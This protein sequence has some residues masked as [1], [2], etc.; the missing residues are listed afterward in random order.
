MSTVLPRRR[1]PGRV[2][3]RSATGRTLSYAVMALM[4][5]YYL[6]PIW[7]LV[8]NS[9]K[10][11]LD[12][13]DSPA[14]WFGGENAF[15][16][17]IA[18]VFTED[19]GAFGFW[20]LNTVFYTV[21]SGFGSLIVSTV[22][23]Y[24]FAKYDFPGKRLAFAALLGVLMVPATALVIPQFLVMTELHLINTPWAV[25]IPGLLNPFGVYLIRIYA[26]D[27]VSDELLEASR[28]DG[29]GEIRAFR[30]VV[31]PLLRPAMATVLI[32]SL[33]G[34]WN[35]YFLPLLMLSDS[36]LFPI[37]VGLGDWYARAEAT[38]GASTPLYNLVITGSLIAIVPLVVSFVVLQRHWTSGLAMGSLK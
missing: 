21:A 32:F 26:Q 5:A 12:L 31:L 20:L 33:V 35:N 17:N 34:A 19:D 8:A 9:T 15:F 3:A 24:A 27:A 18:D 30:S 13:Y 11:N 25:I 10:S 28:L 7:W 6:L 37:T 4:L 1:R 23:G 14:L 29:A 22:A 38:A 2:A 36:R 16:G